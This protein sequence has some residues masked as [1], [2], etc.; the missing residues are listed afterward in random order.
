[1]GETMSAVT[2]DSAE[3]PDKHVWTAIWARIVGHAMDG[4]VFLTLGVA[5]SAIAGSLALNPTQ[6]RSLATITLWS[7]MARLFLI[8]ERK[9]TGLT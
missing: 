1:M 3:R 7:L 2:V 5:L 4:F 6:A 9:R 8:K